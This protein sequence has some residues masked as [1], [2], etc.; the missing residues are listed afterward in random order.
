MDPA[1][2]VPA[3]Q[4]AGDK[5]LTEAGIVAFTLFC[6]LI[7]AVVVAAFLWR[8]LNALT[9]KFITGQERKAE[10][11]MELAGALNKLSDRIGFIVSAR[12]GV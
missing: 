6:M 3:V 5:I 8:R 12:G 9:D 7:L 10:A 11:D 4:G 1:V 2:I